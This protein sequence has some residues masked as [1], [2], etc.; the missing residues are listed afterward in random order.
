ME[1]SETSDGLPPFNLFAN[2]FRI[3]RVH[4]AATNQE[5]RDAFEIAR[6][7]RLAPEDALA[8][9]RD[10]I[11]DLSQRLFH[12]LRYPIDSPR[13]D[14]DALYAILSSEAPANE[15]LLFAGRL[16]PL[17][18]ANFV[19]HIA[20]TRSTDSAVLRA[21]V[22]AH[23]CIEA[24]G[25]YEI[26]KELRRTSENPAPSPASVNQ[27]LQ[28]LLDMHAQAAMARIEGGKDSIE[29]LLASTQQISELGDRRHTEVLRS[30]V[31]AYR[32]SSNL[33]QSIELHQIESA[34]EALQAQPTEA[35]RLEVLAEALV[36]WVSLCRP[37]IA[38]DIHRGARERDL[39]IPT[40]L[41][42]ALIGNLTASQQYDVALKVLDLGRNLLSSMPTAVDQLEG[43]KRL[44]ERLLLDAQMKPL[45]DFI[46]GFQSD[47]RLLNQALKKNGFGQNATD[48]ASGLWRVFVKTAK[49]T[50]PGRSPEPWML[51]RDLA[52][53]LNQNVE[54]AKAAASALIS[55]L[56][57]HGEK[58]AVVPSV[59]HTLRDDLRLI[60]TERRS[61]ERRPTK[62]NHEKAVW[63]A[64]T[65][66][67]AFFVIAFYLGFTRTPFSL[68]TFAR[69]PAEIGS[70]ADAEIKP[71]VGSGQHF[72]LEYVRYCHFQEERLRILKEAVRSAE[73]TR[74]FN[75]LVVDY[76]SRC[77]DFFYRDSDVATVTAEIAANRQRL[78]DEAG[79]IMST[80]PGH[81]TVPVFAQ[82]AK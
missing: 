13:I 54:G 9:A 5:I 53:H 80:W 21:I 51:I 78:T 67:A 68:K 32:R 79:R 49:A 43:D 41:V 52:I 48:A 8:S 74:A 15:L 66:L 28:D 57:H 34:C 29:P 22:D 77:S 14:V 25:I 40:D 75:T 33:Q 16:A 46:D 31:A 11:V 19:A 56:I 58:V 73:D 27:G 70:M 65:T 35:S 23:V 55:G 37:L 36:G 26:L 38:L 17:S 69:A 45:E 24:M 47:F 12:E 20:A 7:Q 1:L 4:P 10:S 39:E 63:L 59:L 71:A 2:P 18:R 82:P 64:G 30:L 44:I 62:P 76:N 61:D 42:R 81:A 60:Q 50:D 3:L 72:S 6:E